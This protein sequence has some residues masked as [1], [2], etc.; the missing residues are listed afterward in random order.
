VTAPRV[1]FH[2][3]FG[4][5]GLDFVYTA[6]MWTSASVDIRTAASARVSE[7]RDELNLSIDHTLGEWTLAAA[8]RVSLERDYR[9]HGPSL[10][11]VWEGLAHNVRIEG[12]A[13]LSDDQVRRAHD[14]G[15]VRPLRSVA[16]WLAYT[17]V[18][19]RGTLLQ[20]A[21]EQR[22][23]LGFH[24]SPYRWV[25]LGGPVTC[26][27]ETTLCVPEVV[28]GRRL[29]YAVA[30]RARQSLARWA[31]LGVGYRYYVDSW[32]LQSH[33]LDASL[34]FVPRTW[35]LMD[36]EYRAY[37]QGAAWFYRSSY[38]VNPPTGFVT[39]DR[40]LS[41]MHDHEVAALARWTHAFP[42][43]RLELSVGLRLAAIAYGYDDF[44]GLTRVFAGE[45]SFNLQLSIL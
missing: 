42:N 3:G 10:G 4:R 1:R 32:R 39:R 30:A 27:A 37:F 2:Q 22:T 44:P 38:P 29:R 7:R 15:F 24:S 19:G 40:E 45:G 20:I 26:T 25:G 5:T 13:S 14:P 23:S 41:P 33:T 17:Q 12:R 34:R 9:A 6:D 43:R 11:A 28:P 8:Y 18:L 21:G 35:L 31:S 16:L 36:L